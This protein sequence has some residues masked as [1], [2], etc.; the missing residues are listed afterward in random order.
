MLTFFLFFFSG[1][2]SKRTL[3]SWS[4][5]QFHSLSLLVDSSSFTEMARDDGRN[6]S[7]AKKR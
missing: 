3:Q 6:W 5:N 7:K 1:C 4:R 2:W